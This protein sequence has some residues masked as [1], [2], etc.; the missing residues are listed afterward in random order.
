MSELS[1]RAMGGGRKVYTINDCAYSAPTLT[2][3]SGVTWGMIDQFLLA[4]AYANNNSQY[5]VAVTVQKLSDTQ[6]I[7]FDDNTDRD[8][9]TDID[10]LATTVNCAGYSRTPQ[11]RVQCMITLK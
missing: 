1:K 4:G 9:R 7:A 5:Q 11:Y 3:P 10:V 2:L 8:R 6:I